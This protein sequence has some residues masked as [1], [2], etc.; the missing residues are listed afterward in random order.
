MLN[1]VYI[2]ICFNLL[3]IRSKRISSIVAFFCGTWP[4]LKGFRNVVRVNRAGLLLGMIVMFN[5]GTH[6]R[7][8]GNSAYV[9]LALTFRLFRCLV[10][11]LSIRS[12][13][14]DPIRVRSRISYL[15]GCAIFFSHFSTFTCFNLH[16]IRHAFVSN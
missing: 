9:N 10:I 3:V 12:I 7:V 13:G 1:A 16:V 11:Y 8:F 15:I 4:F 6:C 5:N 2:R 14:S